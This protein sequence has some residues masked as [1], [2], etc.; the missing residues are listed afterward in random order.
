L[1]LSLFSQSELLSEVNETKRYWLVNTE[2]IK[3]K[4]AID[5][6]T[7]KEANKA[8]PQACPEECLM[9]FSFLNILGFSQICQERTFKAFL[10]QVQAS[11]SPTIGILKASSR[12]G[13]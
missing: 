10:T 6:T 5:V 9:H 7:D 8:H 13:F 12:F 11:S 1:S 2:Y 4:L 3:T